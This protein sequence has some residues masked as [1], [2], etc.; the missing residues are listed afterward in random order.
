MQEMHGIEFTDRYD[1]DP[2]GRPTF[3]TGCHA[4]CMAMGFVPTKQRWFAHRGALTYVGDLPPDEDGFRWVRCPG[5]G[6]TGRVAWWRNLPH[7]GE[8]LW[9]GVRLVWQA[10]TT[11]GMHPAHW[12]RWDAFRMAVWASWGADLGLGMPVVAGRRA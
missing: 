2:R 5:C 9:R 11:P 7:L 4:G 8:W 10:A 3:F 6:G 12:S 1:G